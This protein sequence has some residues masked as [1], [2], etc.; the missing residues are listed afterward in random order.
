[1]HWKNK[2]AEDTSPHGPLR[3]LRYDTKIIVMFSDV[4]KEINKEGKILDV[5]CNSGGVSNY[6][7]NKGYKNIFGFDINNNAINIVMKNNFKDMYNTGNFKCSDCSTGFNTYSSNF[8]DLVF[9]K[10]VL[11]NINY[12]IIDNVISNMVRVSKKYI[13]IFEGVNYGPYNHNFVKIF[14]EKGCN[15]VFE[16]SYEG[17]NSKQWNTITLDSDINSLTLPKELENKKNKKVKKLILFEKK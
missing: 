16:K 3:Y 1:M 17:G 10:G 5:G 11:F 2:K 12:K 13:L 15:I 4:L 6:L 8:F 14:K 7:F 9:S